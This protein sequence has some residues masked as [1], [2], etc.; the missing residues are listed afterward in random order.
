MQGCTST[1]QC[2]L[3]AAANTETAFVPAVTDGYASLPSSAPWPSGGGH[4][5][6]R[7]HGALTVATIAAGATAATEALCVG[8]TSL[9]RMF[10]AADANSNNYDSQYVWGQY[11]TPWGEVKN[12]YGAIDNTNSTTPVGCFESSFATPKVATAMRVRDFCR[13]RWMRSTYAPATGSHYFAIGDNDLNPI[14]AVVAGDDYVSVHTRYSA[15]NYY[16]KEHTEGILTADNA[17]QTKRATPAYG[18]CYIG[19][20]KFHASTATPLVTIYV[21]YYPKDCDQVRNLAWDVKDTN[22][23][24]WDLG[25]PLRPNSEVTWTIED[26][27]AAHAVVEFLVTY[28]EVAG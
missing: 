3:G 11:V 8:T 12:F 13:I 14:Y 15:P 24:V 5:R 18:L 27:N 16:T 22:D 17:Q 19:R 7:P 4:P 2:T 1:A 9:G 20:V 23:H 10:V 6:G 25:I 28:V 26:D 21:T